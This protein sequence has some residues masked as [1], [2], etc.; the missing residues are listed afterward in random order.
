VLLTDHELNVHKHINMDMVVKLWNIYIYI[1]KTGHDMVH[2][3]VV[4]GG[5]G[6]QIWRVVVNILN[7]Q[8]WTADKGW[9]SSLEV[10]ERP[11]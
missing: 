1:Y 8:L 11:N 2:T 7:K 9:S 6:L 10:E 3:Q 4:N 5:Y